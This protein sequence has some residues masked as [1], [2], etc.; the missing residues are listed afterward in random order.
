MKYIKKYLKQ[1]V[2][3]LV[4]ILIVFLGYYLSHRQKYAEEASKDT[5]P[6]SIAK[7]TPYQTNFGFSFMYPPNL[8]VMANGPLIQVGDISAKIEIANCKNPVFSNKITGKVTLYGFPAQIDEPGKSAYICNNTKTACLEI[9]ATNPIKFS[10][11]F[12]HSF[13]SSLNLTKDFDKIPC[14]E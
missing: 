7:W 2:V 11:G 9:E 10:E 1:I 8:K 13:I 12:F 5:I 6:V 3:L 4:L 14:G